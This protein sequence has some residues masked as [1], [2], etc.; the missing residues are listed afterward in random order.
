M[1][2]IKRKLFRCIQQD[3]T[4]SNIGR[5]NSTADDCVVF[6]TAAVKLPCGL[7]QFEKLVGGSLMFRIR[8]DGNHILS[9]ITA[10][11]LLVL[12]RGWTVSR[13]VWTPSGTGRTC[14][15]SS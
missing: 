5:D 10:T 9:A 4:C 14:F 12:R 3:K 1:L 7:E 11:P 15:Y 2:P 13:P 6:H 8:C